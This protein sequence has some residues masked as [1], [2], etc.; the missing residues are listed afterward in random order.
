MTKRWSRLG[1]ASGVVLFLLWAPMALVVVQLPD[2]GSPA[3]VDDF[4]SEHGDLLKVVSLLLSVGF[5]FLLCFLGTLIDRLR[6]AEASGPL[7]WVAFGSSL[8]FMTSLNI[9]IGLVAA[10]GLLSEG[11]G[12]ADVVL[13]VHAAGF[14]IAAPVA[15]AG[16]AFF[17]AVAAL[18][19]GTPVFP[20]WLS[21]FAVV[22]ALANVGAL[23]GLFSLTGPL[24]AGNGVV[25][26]PAVPVVSWVGWILVASLW[27]MRYD[28][29][30][31]DSMTAA[32][33][34][35]RTP[36]PSSSSRPRS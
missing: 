16:A 12:S 1:A 8:M 17:A 7:T 2:L 11:G 5:F 28:R 9:A 32:A 15:L 34:I 26:G 30:E 31:S 21:W 13:G 36:I 29:R 6:R 10:A 18:S 35:S 27:L 4:Y 14:V 33:G 22:A 19:F 23:G 20:R 24:N 25:G 3:R